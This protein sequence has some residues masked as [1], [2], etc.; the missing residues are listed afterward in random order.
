MGK[1]VNREN[2]KEEGL[3]GLRLRRFETGNLKNSIL[4]CDQKWPFFPLTR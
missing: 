1:N 2:E 4:I 3:L